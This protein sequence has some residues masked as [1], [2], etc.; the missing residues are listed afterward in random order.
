[1]TC[2]EHLQKHWIVPLP[3]IVLYAVPTQYND[4]NSKTE[5]HSAGR[6]SSTNAQLAWCVFDVFCW[7]CVGP[8]AIGYVTFFGGV[9]WSKRSQ[10]SKP[11]NDFF[12]EWLEVIQYKFSKSDRKGD[13]EVVLLQ[14]FTWEL[15]NNLNFVEMSCSLVGS[16]WIFPRY[17][18]VDV[19]GAAVWTL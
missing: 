1:M 9:S 7:L 13:L 4:T 6:G 8:F 14:T 16:V 11:A 12:T 17:H 10:R 18:F 15:T 3:N 19:E 2:I 5:D